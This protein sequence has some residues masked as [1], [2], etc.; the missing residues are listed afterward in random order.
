MAKAIAMTPPYN[1]GTGIGRMD[2]LDKPYNWDP[3]AST[4]G[5]NSHRR[6]K[7]SL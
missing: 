1:D 4:S 7:K 2:I 3:P 6:G 5:S